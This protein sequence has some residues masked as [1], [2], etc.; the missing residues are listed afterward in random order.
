M[1]RNRRLGGIGSVVLMGAGVLLLQASGFSVANAQR[2]P[3]SDDTDR[4]LFKLPAAPRVQEPAAPRIQEPAASREQSG[5]TQ[6]KPRGPLPGSSIPGTVLTT[7]VVPRGTLVANAGPV[8]NCVLNPGPQPASG[9]TCNV[10]ESDASGNPSEISNVITLPN[11]VVG[12]FLVLKEDGAIADNVTTN[13]SDVL[14]FGDGS[15]ANTTIVQMFSV[16]C[17]T[18]N[19]NDRSCFPPYSPADSAFI[20][21][22]KSNA[23]VFVANPNTYNIFSVADN[24]PNRPFT[25]ASSVGTVDE[26]STAIVQ[27]R[28][29]TVTLLPAATGSVHIRYNITAIDDISRFCP[30]TQSVVR[31]RFRNSDNSGAT[32]QV[33]FDIHQTNVT[34]GGNN[35]IYSFNSNG[36]GAGTSFATAT[37]PPAIDFDFANN[38]YWIEA[39][40]FR[41]NTGQVA[42]LGSIQIWEAGGTPCP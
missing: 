12:G 3:P 40:I 1:R 35:I 9:F 4:E 15:G 26:D 23:T 41:S 22:N 28:N 33:A 27:L 17:N 31:V 11:L 37:D 16:G 21:E 6:S 29:F 39:T 20:V 24:P 25:L 14:K 42:D 30:A 34:S 13:W 18:G 36:R 32:A 19:P 5:G 2:K 7:D 10:F 8:S 38:I